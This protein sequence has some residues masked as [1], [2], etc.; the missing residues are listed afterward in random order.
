MKREISLWNRKPPNFQDVG[1]EEIIDDEAGLKSFKLVTEPNIS[2][3][4]PSEKNSTGQA[5]LIIPGGGY[6]AVVYEWEG[7]DVAKWLNANGITAFVLKYRLPTAQNNIV[8]HKSPLLDATRAMKII[9]ANAAEWKIDKNQIGVM[10]FSAGGHL[11]STL[12]THFNNGESEIIDKIDSESARPNFIVLLYPV[13]SMVE[14][15]THVGSRINLLGDNLTEELKKKHSNE[16]HIDENTP[17]TF[18]VHSSDDEVV[19]AENSIAFYK[20]LRSKGVDAEMHIFQNGEHGF[21]LA[22][23]NEN[24]EIWKTLCINWLRKQN[25]IIKQI[26]I[27]KEIKRNDFFE[28]STLIFKNEEKMKYGS[29]INNGTEYK[30]TNPHPPRDW[31]NMLW[32][33]TYLACVGQ[34]LNGFSLYQS[35]DGVV[36]NLF[37]KQDNREA[38]RN[39][40]I[41]DNETNETWSAAIKPTNIELEEFSCTHGLGYTILES[42][43]NGVKVSVQIFVPRKEAAEIWSL[44]IKNKSGRERDLSIF[45]VAEAVLDGVNMTYG[46]NSSVDGFYDEKKKRLFFRNRAFNVMKE[47]YRGFTYTDVPFDHFDISKD[48]FQGNDKNYFNPEFY[49]STNLSD[50]NASAELMVS[51][52]QH[53]IKLNANNEKRINFVMGIVLDEEEADKVTS[54]FA[55][56][57][58]IDEE[59][60]KVKYN[61]QARIGL[62]NIKTPDEEFNNLFNVWLKHQV[63]LMADWARFYFKGYRDTLQDSAGMSIHNSDRALAMLEKALTHQKSN[64]FCP[65]AFRVPSM[66]V[67]A[68]DKHY[69][70]SPSWISHATDA[71]L[72]ETG[73]LSILEKVV[74]YSY[75]GEATIW[76]HNLKAIE[77]LWNDRGVHGL[78]LI[79]HGDW[80]DLMDKVGANGKGEGVW[81]SI[82]LARALKLVGKIAAW[83]GDRENE[84]LCKNRYAELKGNIEKHGWDEDHFIYA[85]NDNG[86]KIGTNDS[87]EA[88][89]FINPQS[90]AML[91]GVIDS[92]KYKAIMKKVEPMVDTQVGPVHHWPPFTKYNHEIGTITSVP[93][94]SFTNGNVYC[95]AATFKVAAD[96]LAGRNDK[97]FETFKKILPSEEKSEPYAQ[98]NGYIGPTALRQKKHVSDDP[99]RTGAVAWNILNCYDSLLGFKRDLKGVKIAPQIP[100]TWENVTYTREF[101]GTLFEVNITRGDSTQMLVDGVEQKDCFVEVPVKGLNRKSVKIDFQ[102]NRD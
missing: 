3:F 45:T 70:D 58:L 61:A 16:K 12:G 7:S 39:I 95:H 89:V 55:N 97:A 96:Y 9:R 49:K 64:G 88:Q 82:A 29:F 69:S 17:P 57:K 66:D 53:N 19:N 22:N 11:A 41:R 72:R 60:E 73:D 26:K 42:N 92:D 28:S 81:M 20:A 10:G 1:E 80:N 51:A 31:F 99:W 74:P 32:N 84:E 78:A 37:G 48:V 6:Q 23:G 43:K 30:I 90:W 35:E 75:E 67:A 62:T 2:V 102:I 38:P 68:A 94:G 15:F 46:Y 44:K 36:T 47:K 4:L 83:K 76:E 100:S 14:E 91:S 79:R 93:Q 85:I 65:R 77:F 98:S 5:V 33:P 52:I 8:R 21:S 18:L 54:L 50:S 59:L 40:Y 25:K 56:S 27:K 86:Y 13:I 87:E 24:L 101:R 71:I 63:Y 34:N